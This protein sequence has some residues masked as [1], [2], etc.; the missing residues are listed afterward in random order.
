VPVSIFTGRPWPQPG[1]PLFLRED[2]EAAIALAEEE[3]DTCPSCGMPKAWCRDPEHQFAFD[4]AD[5]VC[6]AT[7]R[8]ELYR[9]SD[10]FKGRDDATRA[11]TH[12]F[13]YFR[14]GFD[15][16][17]TAGLGLDEDE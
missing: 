4:A 15:P 12:P 7:Y 10:K 5:S 8:L 11:A 16:E 1:E 17:L 14:R 13:A 3:Q 2:T 9:E 6:W